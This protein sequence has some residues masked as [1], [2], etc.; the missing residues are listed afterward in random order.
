MIDPCAALLVFVVT[1]LLCVGIKEVVI[2]YTIVLIYFYFWV[3]TILK[4]VCFMSQ[5][6]FVQ[7]VVTIANICAMIFV[8]LAGGYLGFKNGWVGYKVSE[9]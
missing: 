1:S 5:S 2:H 3:E 8:I 9:G 4:L 6:T 7:S